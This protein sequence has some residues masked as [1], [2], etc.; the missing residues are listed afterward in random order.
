MPRKLD[1]AGRGLDQAGDDAQQGGFA[2]AGAAEQADDLAF[3]DGQVDIV[4]HQ[5]LIAAALLEG[6]ADLADVDERG[7]RCDSVT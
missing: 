1:R 5:D 4:E 6:S 2:R 7:R 3:A